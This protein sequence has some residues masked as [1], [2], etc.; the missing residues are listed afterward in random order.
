LIAFEPGHILARRD[1]EKAKM[2]SAA[3]QHLEQ[4]LDHRRLGGTLPSR[5]ADLDASAL[6]ST[7]LAAI[8]AALGGGWRRGAISEVV[9]PRSSGRTTVLLSTLA[10][11]TREG[12]YAALIDAVDRFDLASAL[13]RGLDPARLLWVRGPA[14]TVE[15]ARS[16]SLETVVQQSV[17]AFDLVLR[18]GGFSVV[19][20]DVADLPAASLR[21]LPPATWLR[22]AHANEG[23]SSAGVLIGPSPMGRSARGRTIALAG[24]PI[25]TGDSAQSWRFGGLDVLLSRA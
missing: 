14:L 23:R 16:A 17:R 20:L 6:A 22:L 7:G 11:A 3:L 13:A 2:S 5:T 1:E 9:G 19:L 10:R 4:L 18:A 25:W 12:E 21:A 8:D 15:L 24:R